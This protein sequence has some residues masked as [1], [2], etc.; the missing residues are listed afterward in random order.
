MSQI[1]VL[2]WGCPQLGGEMVGQQSASVEAL[3]GCAGRSR[4]GFLKE[5]T[6]EEWKEEAEH[7]LGRE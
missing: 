6:F 5:A 3:V 7:S 4:G 2:P 1:R